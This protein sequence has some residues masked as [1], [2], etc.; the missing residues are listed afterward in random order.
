[1]NFLYNVTTCQD[2]T[3]LNKKG[4]NLWMYPGAQILFRETLVEH[5]KGL[6]NSNPRYGINEPIKVKVSC[7]GVKMSRTT[8]FVILSFAML[9]TGNQVMS[10]KGNRTIAIV[11]GPEKYKTLKSSLSSAISEINSVISDGHILVDGEQRKIDLYLGGDYKFLLMAMGMKGATSDYA[12][13]WCKVHMLLRWDTSKGINF[14]SDGV[15]KRTLEE[16]KHCQTKNEYSCCDHP[17]LNIELDHIVLDELHLM[18]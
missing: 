18:L 9:Q 3:L 4:Q 10:S 12:C 8:N 2:L 17:L 11:N 16:I 6:L 13:L 15:M 1:M 5:I 7:D 14:Y